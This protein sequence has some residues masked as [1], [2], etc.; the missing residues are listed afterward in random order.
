[1]A[2]LLRTLWAYRGFGGDLASTAAA[3]A[4]HRMADIVAIDMAA[5]AAGEP[6]PWRS[7]NSARVRRRA[8]TMGRLRQMSHCVRADQPLLSLVIWC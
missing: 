8:P 1:M 2:L 4:V 3:L 6:S 7:S 5:Q